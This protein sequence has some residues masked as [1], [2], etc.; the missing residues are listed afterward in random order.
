MSA[1]L[2]LQRLHWPGC[3]FLE[4]EAYALLAGEERVLCQVRT[5]LSSAEE[6]TESDLCGHKVSRK[7]HENRPSLPSQPTPSFKCQGDVLKQRALTYR[8]VFEFIHGLPGYRA[9]EW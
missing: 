5:L 8:Y 4:A 9:T 6:E 3:L 2:R 7:K 1:R